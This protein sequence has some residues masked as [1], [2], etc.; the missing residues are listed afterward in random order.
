L[1]LFAS[2]RFLPLFEYSAKADMQESASNLLF[3]LQMIEQ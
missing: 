1:F 3:I 2:A